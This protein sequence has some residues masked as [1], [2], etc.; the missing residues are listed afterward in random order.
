MAL[1]PMTGVLR[2]ENRGGLETQTHIGRR[3]CEN[4]SNWSDAAISQ[5]SLESPEAARGKE[6]LSPS[7]IKFVFICY[8]SYGKLILS[9]KPQAS[10]SLL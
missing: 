2:R 9:L 10:C 6:G 8:S 4:R 1:N 7:A 3:L 5:G